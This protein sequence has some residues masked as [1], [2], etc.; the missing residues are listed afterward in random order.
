MKQI[1][2]VI[3]YL[4]LIHVMFGIIKP[5]S[6]LHCIPFSTPMENILHRR[7]SSQITKMQSS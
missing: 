4:P 6:D 3:Y 5:H 2:H 7:Y 1:H